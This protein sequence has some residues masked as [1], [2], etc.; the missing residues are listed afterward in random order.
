MTYTNYMILH[1]LFPLN[2]NWN[3]S[4]LD[5]INFV[6]LF[7]V[8][9]IAVT[10]SIV[11]RIELVSFVLL[12]KFVNLLHK[13]VINF[14]SDRWYW[15]FSISMVYETRV[16]RFVPP[17]SSR[18]DLHPQIRTYSRNPS[19]GPI[20]KDRV[21]GTRVPRCQRRSVYPWPARIKGECVPEFLWRAPSKN[22]TINNFSNLS[23]AGSWARRDRFGSECVGK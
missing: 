18:M 3:Y 5:T 14:T 10:F 1:Y 9:T 19:R 8:A 7:F 17:D 13:T 6:S 15:Q 12:K 16:G 20:E 11:A 21:K 2:L 4:Q 22:G 23:P